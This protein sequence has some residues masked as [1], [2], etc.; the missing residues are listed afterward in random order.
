MRVPIQQ[1]WWARVGAFPASCP[2]E[3][4]AGRQV[5]LAEAM[6]EGP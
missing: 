2:G 4:G 5:T 1:V 3:A 6:L